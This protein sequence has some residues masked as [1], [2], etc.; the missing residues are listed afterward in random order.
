[1]AEVLFW[2]FLS[3]FGDLTFWL[4]VATGSLLVYSFL[5]KR[6]RH[7][8]HWVLF[9]VLPAVVI[10]Y[11]V[12]LGLKLL[13]QIPRPCSGLLCPTDYSFPSGHATVIFAAMTLLF[14]VTKDRKAKVV[15]LV[16]ASLVGLSRFFLG[17]H[18]IE[19][20]IVGALIGIAVGYITYHNHRDILHFAHQIK[21]PKR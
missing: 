12:T 7:Y 18:R 3:Y 6:A 17:L 4:G 11:T 9:G 19:D 8:L 15:Y 2:E 5:P 13:F 16:F 10:S 21:F 14:F 1:M 20:V